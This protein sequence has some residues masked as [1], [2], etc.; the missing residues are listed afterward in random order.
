MAASYST[1]PRFSSKL[2]DFVL[3]VPKRKVQALRVWEQE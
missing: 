2:S 1:R 3:V